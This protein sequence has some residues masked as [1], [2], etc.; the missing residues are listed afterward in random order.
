MKQTAKNTASIN[1]PSHSDHSI[2]CRHIYET[3][4]RSIIYCF[5]NP[6]FHQFVQFFRSH[7]FGI[8][9]W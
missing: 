7:S 5:H 1:I 9:G 6:L 4:N 3:D 2:L 8:N